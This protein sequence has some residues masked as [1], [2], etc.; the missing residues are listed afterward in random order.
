MPNLTAKEKRYG[1]TAIHVNPDWIFEPDDE[2]QI[3]VIDY[4]TDDGTEEAAYGYGETVKA[5]RADAY[6]EVRWNGKEVV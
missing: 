4:V 1:A 5:A 3:V 2:E 6:D